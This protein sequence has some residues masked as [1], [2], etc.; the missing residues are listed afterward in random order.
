M[1]RHIVAPGDFATFESGNVHKVYG[2]FALTRDAEWSSRLFVTDMKDED[3]EGIGT[4]VQVEHIAPAFEGEEVEFVATIDKID[5]NNLFCTVVASVGSRIVA[6]CKT[7][8]K[9]M[10]KEKLDEIFASFQ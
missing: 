1:H 5:K 4:Y 6:K 9:I 7:G 3:E 8:Q 10:K 2:T